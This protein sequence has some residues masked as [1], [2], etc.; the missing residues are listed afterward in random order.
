MLVTRTRTVRIVDPK[1]LWFISDTHF[2]HKNIAKFCGRDPYQDDVAAMD[3]RIID[4][5]IAVVGPQDEV[6]HLGDFGFLKSS[7]A[8]S[9]LDQLTG[10]IH[11]V[12]GNHDIALK[13]EVLDRFVSV[14]N[15][16]ELDVGGVGVVLSH[17]PLATWNRSHYGSLH[18]HGH[19]HGSL[20]AIKNRIDVGVDGHPPVV[21]KHFGPIAWTSLIGYI[22][23]TEDT[24]ELR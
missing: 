5:W 23:D 3:R 13:A 10:R 8:H 6:W 7:R 15:M 18:F 16:A 14:Q 9:I 1:R 17:F 21:P 12:L 22:E 11:L 19:C 24:G 2:G 4:E 20:P